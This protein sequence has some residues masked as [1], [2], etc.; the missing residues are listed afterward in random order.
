MR[1]PGEAGR[2]R[3]LVVGRELRRDRPARRRAVRK[4]KAHHV[5]VREQAIDIG[6]IFLVGEGRR[7][8]VE[9]GASGIEQR[10]LG[11]R[12]EVG[13]VDEQIRALRRREHEAAGGHGHGSS[14][15]SVIGAD[16]HD[17]AQIDFSVP[18]QN[19]AVGACVRPV[20]DAEAVGG[21][22]HFE[23]GARPCRSPW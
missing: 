3:R 23:D 19:Q 8:A 18:E 1:H 22:F 10:Q 14:K 16:L 7:G 2:G 13:E 17:P 20:E 9:G 11:A 12:V 21:R 4:A 6:C 5:R 15:E